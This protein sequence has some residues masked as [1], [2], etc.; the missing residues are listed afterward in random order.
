MNQDSDLRG[1]KKIRDA[2]QETE[3]TIEIIAEA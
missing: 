1:E 3:V 2:M